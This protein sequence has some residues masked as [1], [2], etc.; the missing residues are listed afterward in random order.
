M[1]L[2][3]FP[4]SA[5]GGLNLVGDPE[6]VGLNGAIDMMNVDLDIRGRLRTR[7]GFDNFTAAVGANRYDGIGHIY[8]L[9]GNKQVLSSSTGGSIYRV[10]D[11]TGAIVSSIAAIQP[12]YEIDFTR[13]GGPGAQVV[14]ITSTGVDPVVGVGNANLPYK[15]DGAAWTLT[16]LNLGGVGNSPLQ[17]EVKPSDNRLV[18]LFADSNYS[19][20]GFSG[21]GVPETWGVNDYVDLTPGDGERISALAVWREFVFAFKETKFFVFG[22]TS[23]SG[24]GTP[25]FNYRAVRMGIGN[26]GRNCVTSSPNGVYFV[27]RRGIYRTTGDAPVLVSRAID[28]IF[29]GGASSAYTGGTLN[30][31]YIARCQMTWSNERLYFAYPSGSSTVNDRLLVFDPERDY[32]LLWNIPV[33]SMTTFRVGDTE[34]LLF[35]YASGSNHLGRFNSTFTTDDGAAIAAYYQ[36]GFYQPSPTNEVS[37]RWTE[38]WGTGSPTFNIFTNHA[39]SD[40]L[41]RGG[42][43]TLGTAPQVA[44]GTHLKAYTGQLLSHKLSST[45]GA[46]SVNRIE[47]QITN[48]FSPQ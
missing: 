15:W 10:F 20:V 9:G 30:P 14:Y 33:N 41:L 6:E 21:A 23:T 26:V 11:T 32:W 8:R 18:G 31:A 7:D 37:T 13:F 4:I 28:P 46:W 40:P 2:S 45:S 27:T 19:R 42:T 44:K 39:S 3:G 47:H 36:S 29:V 48:V 25:T 17:L 43:V 5:F 34:D 16:P 24:T 22:I 35:G 12:P 38:I 1:P